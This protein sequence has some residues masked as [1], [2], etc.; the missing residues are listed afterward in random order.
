MRI[1]LGYSEFKGY[2]L[3]EIP[4]ALTPNII[5]TLSLAVRTI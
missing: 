4:D 3:S 5:R 2:S 1:I